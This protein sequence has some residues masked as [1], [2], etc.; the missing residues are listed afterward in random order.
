MKAR[1]G[2]KIGRRNNQPNGKNG[3]ASWNIIYQN[4]NSA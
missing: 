4:L 2:S 3:L 1:R